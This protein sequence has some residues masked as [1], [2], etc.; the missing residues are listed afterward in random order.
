MESFAKKKERAKKIFDGL[1]K[2]YPKATCALRHHNAWELLVSTILSAQCTDKRVNMVTPPLFEKLPNIEA[3]AK[4]DITALET[5][6]KSTGF[7]HNKAKNI[8]GAAIKIMKKF[9]GK[10]PDN[11]RDLIT[12]PGVARKTANVVLS[13]W[14]KKNEGVV[15]DTHVKRITNRLGLTKEQNPEK[16]EKDLMK[17]FEQNDWDTF[18]HMLVHHGRALCTAHKTKCDQCLI[19][20]ICPSA[21]K[22]I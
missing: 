10:V 1:E 2:M 19:N 6:V 11:M 18:S 12:L 16:I 5:M 7:Y 22:S 21:G 14:F 9:N 8:Q 15:V 13:V 20:N 3:F 4:C 17:L